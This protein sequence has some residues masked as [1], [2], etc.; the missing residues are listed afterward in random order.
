MTAQVIRFPIE[1]RVAD[2]LKA[3]GGVRIKSPSVEGLRYART[4]HMAEREIA[5]LIRSELRS[6]PVLKDG[7]VAS[8]VRLRRFAGGYAIDVVIEAP[9]ALND[10]NRET[11]RGRSLRERAEAIRQAYNR[12]GGSVTDYEDIR[13]YGSTSWG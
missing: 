4:K 5:A 13:Y 7:C 8:S 6:D 1:R 3:G 10:R 12:R 11:P 9:G 2:I